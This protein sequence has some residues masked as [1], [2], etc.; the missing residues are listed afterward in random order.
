M[1]EPSTIVD[2][3]GP[4]PKVIREGKVKQIIKTF[5]CMLL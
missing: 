5:K 1:A 3:T 4:Y 2:M